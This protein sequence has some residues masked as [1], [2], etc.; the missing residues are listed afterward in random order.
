MSPEKYTELSSRIDALQMQLDELKAE[1]SRDAAEEQQIPSP[2]DIS[3]EDESIVAEEPAVAEDSVVADEPAVV[4]ELEAAGEPEPAGEPASAV[5]TEVP[6]EM[7]SQYRW[8]LDMP[9]SPVSNIISGISLNDRVLLIKSVFGED[10]M[11][12]QKTVSDLNSMSTLQE[13]VGYML[14]NF[15]ELKLGS[16]AVYR[17]M[18]AVRRKLR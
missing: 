11:L 4:E 17:L 5:S 13:A 18:M 9:G 15:P 14:Q 2:L 10:P 16:D 1:L 8:M 12:F 7:Y 3:L 6:L